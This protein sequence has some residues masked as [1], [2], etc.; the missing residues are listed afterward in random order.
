MV[1]PAAGSIHA[2]LARNPSSAS[3]SRA[4]GSAGGSVASLYAA[5]AHN[6]SS[7]SACGVSGSAGGSVASGAPLAIAG[8]GAASALPAAPKAKAKAKAN[9]ALRDAGRRS[10]GLMRGRINITIGKGGL[11]SWH[12]LHPS[13]PLFVN[14]VASVSKE[15]KEVFEKQMG[16]ECEEK[17]MG[18]LEIKGSEGFTAAERVAV[19]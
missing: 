17:K 18:C 5:V 10:T 16:G 3:A 13:P 12:V 19:L 14:D 6:P 15:I 8:N 9:A 4:S 1:R 7:A 2:A 11:V